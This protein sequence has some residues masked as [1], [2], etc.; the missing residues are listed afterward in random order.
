M[1]N[2][3]PMLRRILPGSSPAPEPVPIVGEGR[4]ITLERVATASTSRPHFVEKRPA[5]KAGMVG[6]FHNDVLQPVAW[7][8]DQAIELMGVSWMFH[9]VTPDREKARDTKMS[10]QAESQTPKKYQAGATL[11]DLEYLWRKKG[12]GLERH[13]ELSAR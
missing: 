3:I 1:V 2:P 7:T 8:E 12:K 5:S 13:R 10:Q 9:A 4:G 11:E 6:G